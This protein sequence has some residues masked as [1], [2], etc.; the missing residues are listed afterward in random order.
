MFPS[1]WEEI[2]R[3]LQT[4][5]KSKAY[6]WYIMLHPYPPSSYSGLQFQWTKWRK[7]S[8]FPQLAITMSIACIV[9]GWEIHPALAASSISRSLAASSSASLISIWPWRR[10]RPNVEQLRRIG[11]GWDGRNDQQ[12]RFTSF[13]GRYPVVNIQKTMENPLSWMGKSTINHHFQ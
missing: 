8:N 12:K 3:I 9:H 5:H 13:Y 11:M 1:S 7:K 4:F 6:H 2:D 10:V